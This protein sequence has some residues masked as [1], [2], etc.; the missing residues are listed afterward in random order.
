MAD[1]ASRPPTATVICLACEADD[2]PRLIA[3]IATLAAELGGQAVEQS[4]TGRTTVM[5]ISMPSGHAHRF[6][7][8]LTLAGATQLDVETD[9]VGPDFLLLITFERSLKSGPSS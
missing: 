1:A 2:P 6:A 5:R 4:V 8:A 3:E 7:A 9:A